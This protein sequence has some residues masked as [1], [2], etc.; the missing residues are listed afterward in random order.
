MALFQAPTYWKSDIL[1]LLESLCESG[2]NSRLNFEVENETRV[3]FENST[4]CPGN[5][6]GQGFCVEDGCICYYGYFGIECL[7]Q[8]GNLT[9]VYTLVVYL[10]YFD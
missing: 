6:Y 1:R 7:Q 3:E 4:R 5:C 10:L 9:F 2:I 8:A